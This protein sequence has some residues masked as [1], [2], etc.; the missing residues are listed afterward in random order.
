[1]YCLPLS[2]RHQY[3]HYEKKNARN[4]FICATRE[5]EKKKK[6]RRRRERERER[7]RNET[8]YRNILHGQCIRQHWQPHVRAVMHV[9]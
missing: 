3:E 4:I 2:P 5:K 9:L 8:K 1:M 6:K 7:E